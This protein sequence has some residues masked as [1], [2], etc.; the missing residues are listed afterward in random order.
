VADSPGTLLRLRS[1]SAI[2]GALKGSMHHLIDDHVVVEA[3]ARDYRFSAIQQDETWRRWRDGESFN[4]MG[5]TLGVPMHHVRNLLAQTSGVGQAPQ[6]RSARHLRAAER[7]E[8]SRDIAAGESARR[9][10]ARLGRSPSTL[11]PKIARNGGPQHHRA[12]LADQA[13]YRRA[14]RPKTLKLSPLPSLRAVVE[15]KP[16]LSWSPEQS[17]G[18]LRRQFPHDPARRIW[19]EAISLSPDDPRPRQ[20]INGKL[21]QRLRT[22]RPMRQKARRPLGW[23]IIRDMASSPNVWGRSRTVRFPGPGRA[24]S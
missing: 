17:T 8:I 10:A 23:G 5:Q 4:S 16:A 2:D 3:Q 13:A 20:A 6:R 9:I 24:I 18:W 7:E 14:R 1:S 19:H 22:A 21:T 12:T 15:D 11:S